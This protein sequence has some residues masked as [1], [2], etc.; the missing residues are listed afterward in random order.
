MEDI[1]Q[2]DCERSFEKLFRLFYQRLL[3]FSI[4]YVDNKESAE[5]IVSDVFTKL[6]LNRKNAG[7]IRN[8]ETYLFIA[9][10]NHSLNYLKQFSHYKLV[11]LEET[12]IHQLINTHDP[13][14]ELEK[15][16]L[17]FKM[18]QAI[19]SLP[20]QCKIVFNLVKEDGLKYKQVAEILGISSRTVE[21]QLVRAVKK[22]DKI[23]NSYISSK[24][25][26]D[27]EGFHISRTIKSLLFCYNFFLSL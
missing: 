24:D 23:I 2:K 13:E 27:K 1:R 11:F 4:Q 26:G 14:K 20:R 18:N 17:I 5:E 15:Q 25:E 21:T 8:L 19:D 10:K 6:W 3:N 16:E 9:V 7:H 12:G 22:L